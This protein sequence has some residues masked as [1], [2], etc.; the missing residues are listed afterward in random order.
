[1][2]EGTAPD[3]RNIEDLIRERARID[4]ELEEALMEPMAVMFT[5]IKGSTSFFEKR[6]DIEGLL[7]VEK[8]NQMLFPIIEGHDGVVI[9]TM[10]DAIM[11][12]FRSPEKAARASIQ[13]QRILHKHNLASPKADRI[14][15]RIGLNYGKGMIKNGDVYGDVVNV[16]ARVEQT[17]QPGHILMSSSMAGPL[18]DFADLRMTPFSRET[19]RGKADPFDIYRLVWDEEE[20]E[21]L[22]AVRSGA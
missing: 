12:R 3:G 4:M 8:H 22:D 20:A 5:D 19:V 14:E 16:A 2:V 10:G 6:G 15:I 18:K 17:C 9:K 13:M 21:A 11:A 7:M 1:M